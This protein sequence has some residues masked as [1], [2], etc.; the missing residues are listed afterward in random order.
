M[1]KVALEI[2]SNVVS[3]GNKRSS[4]LNF[5]CCFFYLF[6]ILKFNPLYHFCNQLMAFEFSPMLLCWCRKTV[7][8]RK[9]CLTWTTPFC[10]GWTMPY[11]CK[12]WFNRIGR[13]DMLPV[14]RR[15]VIESKEL[16]FILPKT[17]TS[18]WIFRFIQTWVLGCLPRIQ[19][20][21]LRKSWDFQ[22]K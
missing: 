8:H 20:S 5:L 6:S 13:S 18:F 15:K 17:L 7:N 19:R 4:N 14:H 16:F 12:C 3:W 1:E 2:L 10:L 9:G 21:L 22:T 11:G